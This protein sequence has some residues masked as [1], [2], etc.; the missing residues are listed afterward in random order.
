MELRL[1]DKQER[2]VEIEVLGEDETL[3][4]PLTQKLMDDKEVEYAAYILGHPDL[5]FPTLKIRVKKGT[6]EAALKRAIKSLDKDFA[7][8]QK[9]LQREII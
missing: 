9:L 1:V 7:D 6:P 4:Y 8:L 5:D 2:F 3:L